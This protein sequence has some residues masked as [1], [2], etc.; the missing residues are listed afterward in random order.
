MCRWAHALSQVI[1]AGQS[2][3]RAQTHA[4]SAA[5]QQAGGPGAGR[6]TAQSWFWTLPQRKIPNVW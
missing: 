1:R 5:P 2:C 4:V 6:P 3:G